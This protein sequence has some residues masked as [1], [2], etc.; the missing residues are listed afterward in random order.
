VR[1]AADQHVIFGWLQVGSIF[2]V[3]S[4]DRPKW[5]EYHPHCHQRFIANASGPNNTL[6]AA[7]DA[8]MVNG[9]RLSIAGYGTFRHFKSSLCLTYS[10]QPKRSLW[11]LPTW[12][13]PFRSSRT[14]LSYHSDSKRWSLM[15][16]RCLLATVGRGQE[17]VLNGDEYPEAADWL[18]S[19]LTEHARH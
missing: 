8:L 13:Y 17:F 15:E 9:G 10:I 7:T 12:F 2:P 5:T 4:E 18:I 6:Y 3:S 16:D 19:I 1:D 14:P 11:S